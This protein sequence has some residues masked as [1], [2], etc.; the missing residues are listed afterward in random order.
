MGESVI[1]KA[2]KPQFG[3]K[4][5][6]DLTLTLTGTLQERLARAKRFLEAA[7]QRQRAYVDKGRR[8]L[9]FSVGDDVLLS[10]ANISFKRVGALKLMSRYIG[11]FKVV[12]RIGATAYE[13]ELA[14][15][16]RIHDVFHVSLLKS[17]V[18]GRGFIRPPR[19]P[20]LTDDGQVE[21]EVERI[22]QHKDRR[23]WGHKS[24]RWYYVH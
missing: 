23:Y 6:T 12:K 11:P 17:Y 5:F 2:V 18:P 16:M 7:Q 1:Y 15:N 14:K 20:Q 4:G 10:T 21:F 8:P 13:L 9:E 24:R 19:A 22:M 3:T